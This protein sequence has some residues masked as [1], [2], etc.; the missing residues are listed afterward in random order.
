MIIY[1]LTNESIPDYIKIGRADNLEKR[2]KQLHTTGVPLPFECFYARKITIAD[3][4]KRIHSIFDDYRVNPKREFFTVSQEK[5][6]EVLELIEGEDVT[7]KDSF[8]EDKDDLLKIEKSKEKRQNFNFKLFG[9][10]IGSELVFTKNTDKKVVVSSNKNQVKIG[11]E[12]M[13]I[14]AAALKFLREYGYNWESARGAE[15]FTYHGEKL[16]NL[17]ERLESE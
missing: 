7:P 3:A 17:R 6:K 8:I 4:E 1:I 5:V 12:E 10:E 2:M 9:I 11:E 14:S 15:Y 13:S 16:T